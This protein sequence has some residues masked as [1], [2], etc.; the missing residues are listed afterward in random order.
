[1][2]LELMKCN[3]EGTLLQAKNSLISENYAKESCDLYLTDELY[4]DESGSMMKYFKLHAN[5][6][7]TVEQGL[8][9]D[10]KCP[11]CGALFKRV[12][13]QTSPND[14]SLFTCTECNRRKAGK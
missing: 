4:K 7:H 10:I 1:M 14:L 13:R 5:A 11:S 2:V 3:K 9:Y 8:V 6:T 12:G